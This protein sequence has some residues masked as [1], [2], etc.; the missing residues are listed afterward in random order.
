MLASLLGC[1][2]PTP[3]LHGTAL[4]PPAPAPDFEL[5]DQDGEPWTL[6]RARGEPALL[7][8]GFTTCAHTC[9]MVLSRL[10]AADDDVHIVLV[11]VDPAR[12]T[13]ERLSGWLSAFGPP[14]TG[15]TGDPQVLA[16]VRDAYGAWVSTAGGDLT[17]SG[18]VYGIDRRGQLRVVLD[19]EA[20][21]DDLADDVRALEVM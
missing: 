4:V 14:I 19:P 10:R 20:P 11:T 5:V 2:A 3:E 13:P 21:L 9:P 6:A 12:D 18:V 15:L 16:Q 7:F 8:F 1:G 17:H